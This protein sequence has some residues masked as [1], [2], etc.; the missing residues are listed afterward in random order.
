MKI[1]LRKV[2]APVVTMNARVPTIVGRFNFERMSSVVGRSNTDDSRLG[3]VTTDPDIHDGTIVTSHGYA[4]YALHKPTNT[5]CLI[6]SKASAN[7][8]GIMQNSGEIIATKDGL[9]KSYIISA[10]RLSEEG[11]NIYAIAPKLRRDLKRFGED[12]GE[13]SEKHFTLYGASFDERDVDPD[14]A[15]KESKGKAKSKNKNKNKNK[16]SVQEFEIYTNGR[17]AYHIM[18]RKGAYEVSF[19]APTRRK[20]GSFVPIN[21]QD[22]GLSRYFG[23]VSKNIAKE[24]TY[25]E[26]HHKM[27]V[28]WQRISSKLWDETNIFE[29]EGRRFNARKTLADIYNHAADHG[30]R[31]VAV[32][33]LVGL[34]TGIINPAYGLITG[35]IAAITHTAMDI[36]VDEGYLASKQA[37]ERTKEAKRK[38]DISAYDFDKSA[39]DHF[40]IQ[41]Q[42]N[43]NKLCSKMDLERFKAED[44]VFLT[45]KHS[46]VL[47]DHEQVMDGFRPSSLRAHLIAVHQR[48]FSSSCVLPD[49]HTRVDAFQSGLI[50]F[51]H[52]KAN[53]EIVVYARYRPD[54]CLVDALRLPAD[55][56]ATMGDDIWR[57][58][59]DRKHDNFHNAFKRDV[60]K[61]TL[62]EMIEDIGQNML[63]RDRPEV[64]EDVKK[65]SL[66]AIRCYFNKPDVPQNPGMYMSGKAIHP[67]FLKAFA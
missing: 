39:A 18:K 22:K 4:R 47:R 51:L 63:F 56:I 50:R 33:L 13:R 35:M 25:Q 58:T 8:Q 53:G 38:L 30:P 11:Q 46:G 9:A 3:G 10:Y 15:A 5:I 34:L 1:M 29:G 59:Y 45:S 28:H 61:I 16:N 31:T 43:I 2:E 27:M 66:G 26:A 60:R 49:P 36:V 42:N 67:P 21:L 44:F 7:I 19:H 65:R 37:L 64:D 57:F 12:L 23:S 40:K 20:D 24:K 55:K 52:E 54:A 62:D 32:T 6:A 41:T 14:I 48:G 17:L